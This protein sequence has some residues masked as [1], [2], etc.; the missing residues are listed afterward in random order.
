MIRSSDKK[1]ASVRKKSDKRFCNGSTIESTV[2]FA[3]WLGRKNTTRVCV[4][5]R[6]IPAYLNFKYLFDNIT[7][8]LCL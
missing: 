1:F 3:K 8:R 7:Y 2:K 4:T 5:R 6:M